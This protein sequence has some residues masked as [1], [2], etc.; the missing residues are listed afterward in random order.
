MDR[1]TNTL[2]AFMT[3][4]QYV[5]ENKVHENFLVKA[6]TWPIRKTIEGLFGIKFG[7]W[8]LVDMKNNIARF[9][10]KKQKTHY[11]LTAKLDKNLAILPGHTFNIKF[12]KKAKKEEVEEI[13]QEAKHKFPESEVE[14]EK[15]S[16]KEEQMARLEMMK[17]E[18]SEQSKEFIDSFGKKLKV[19]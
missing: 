12:A 16:R 15:M 17:K 7:E 6:L 3:F 8:T 13:K 9:A 4:E 10:I 1:S 5:L 11:V 2:G 14:V 19:K 18:R